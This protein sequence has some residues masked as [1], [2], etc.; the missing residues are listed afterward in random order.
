MHVEQNDESCVEGTGQYNRWAHSTAQAAS[1]SASRHPG[2][3]ESE[4]VYANNH[5][6]RMAGT[7]MELS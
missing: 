4:S 7:R 3:Y 1:D 2:S 6:A 5:G